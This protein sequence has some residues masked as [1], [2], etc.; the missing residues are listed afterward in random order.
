ME[1]DKDNSEGIESLINQGNDAFRR[2][3]YRG[4]FKFY[5]SILEDNPQYKKAW[6]NLGGVHERVGNNE[7]AARCY[8][9]AI[10]IDHQYELALK[11]LE[12]IANQISLNEKYRVI[13]VIAFSIGVISFGIINVL[14]GIG[15]FF[16]SVG[17][18]GLI[19]T[20]LYTLED[21]IKKK[22]SNQRILIP[23]IFC[24]T[25]FMIGLIIFSINLR[26]ALFL[27]GLGSIIF[28]GILFYYIGIL[29]IPSK[30]DE[31]LK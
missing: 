4:T 15:I 19:T 27:F 18:G 10:E 8:K 9:R 1:F 17:T 7:E 31:Y 6:N 21:D 26:I 12:K 20:A 14:V 22:L 30:K 29:I 23:V 25:N 28:N 24:D 13:L 16:I 2:K 3:D 5:N 11:N